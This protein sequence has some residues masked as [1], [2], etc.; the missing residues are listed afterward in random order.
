VTIV[1][2]ISLVF[3]YSLVSRRLARTVVTAPIVFTAAG[4]LISLALPGLAELELGREDRLL[5]AEVALVM[6]LFTDATRVGLR[7]L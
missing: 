3:L 2:F 1:L 4:M 7:D 6:L 5:L